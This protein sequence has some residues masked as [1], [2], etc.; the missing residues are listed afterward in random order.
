MIPDLLSAKFKYQWKN[1]PQLTPRWTQ[2]MTGWEILTSKARSMVP[3]GT[4]TWFRPRSRSDDRMTYECDSKLG[5]P[6]VIDCAQLLQQPSQNMTILPRDTA[7]VVSK[8]CSVAISVTSVGTDAVSITWQPVQAALAL[9]ITGCVALVSGNGSGGRAQ[10]ATPRQLAYGHPK[11]KRNSS[12]PNGIFHAIRKYY[13]IRQTD[14][15]IAL[16]SLLPNVKITVFQQTARFTT[17]AAE[18][19]SCPW[20]AAQNGDDV[21]QCLQEL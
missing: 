12:E 5:N 19:R 4:E 20:R 3:G 13:I 18:R 15:S 8:S 2:L 10:I 14:Q 11:A 21:K 1:T 9:I 17:Y 6:S 16:D 7:F